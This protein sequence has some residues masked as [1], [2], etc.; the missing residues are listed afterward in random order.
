M[1][2]STILFYSKLDKDAKLSMMNIIAKFQSTKQYHIKLYFQ[3][4]DAPQNYSSLEGMRVQ[5]NGIKYF[6]IEMKIINS[7]ENLSS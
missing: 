3:V 5:Y 2:N 7:E 4:K 1:S 6:E